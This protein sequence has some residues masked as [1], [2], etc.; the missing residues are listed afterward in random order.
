MH[1]QT[2]LSSILLAVSGLGVSAR[3]MPHGHK[4]VGVPQEHFEVLKMRASG[5]VNPSAVT[6]VKC[7]DSNARVVF[8]DQ[9]V[10]ELAICG[11]IAGDVSKCGGSP[12]QTVGESGSARF[13]LK[14]AQEG[15]TIN[16]SKTR[17]EQCV[18]AA[19]DACPTGT[20]SGTCVGGASSGDV[21]FTLNIQ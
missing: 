12:Q 7:I 1:F 19:R 8:H 11:G 18:R 3:P 9:N 6:G 21:D 4:N 14:A 20:M 13:E 5:S 2:L 16:I 10:A 15:A 17:W